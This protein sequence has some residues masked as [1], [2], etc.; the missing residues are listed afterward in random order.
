[1]DIMEHLLKLNL[2]NSVSSPESQLSYGLKKKGGGGGQ[3]IAVFCVSLR[4]KEKI[5]EKSL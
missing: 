5:K 4:N 3:S 1:M 2:E